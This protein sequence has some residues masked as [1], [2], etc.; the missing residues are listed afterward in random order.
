MTSL[1]FLNCYF[2]DIYVRIFDLAPADGRMRCTEDA[3]DQ[4][5]RRNKLMATKVTIIA[6]IEFK[7]GRSGSYSGWRIG[8]THD[9]EGSKRD[10]QLMQGRNVDRWCDW[11]ANS[12]GEAEE[13]QGHFTEKGMSGSAGANLLRYKPVYVYI[14]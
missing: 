10:W 1:Q 12:L 14:F 4:V 9:P 5:T 8:L 2:W 3:T 6:G 11:Q 13:I 7:V